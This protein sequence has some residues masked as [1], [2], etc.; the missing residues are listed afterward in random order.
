[1]YKKVRSKNIFVYAQHTQHIQNQ[2]DQPRM[3]K[4]MWP[5]SSHSA[6]LVVISLTVLIR[7]LRIDG[8]VC[9]FPRSPREET[10]KKPNNKIILKVVKPLVIN[11][12]CFREFK[13]GTINCGGLLSAI[14][15]YI[16]LL[17]NEF[18][19]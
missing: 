3:T 7:V 10:K 1:M 13:F 4:H 2:K 11:F 5:Y 12:K 6:T 14:V 17:Q 9:Y 16:C 15:D 18:N 19:Y 8:C